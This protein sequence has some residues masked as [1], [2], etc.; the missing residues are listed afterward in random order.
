[1]KLKATNLSLPDNLIATARGYVNERKKNHRRFSISELVTG[2]LVSHLRS[3][4][5]KLPEE[6][7][8]KQSGGQSK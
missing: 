8:L 6:F 2:L 3:K 1:M 5:V 4:G 7:C